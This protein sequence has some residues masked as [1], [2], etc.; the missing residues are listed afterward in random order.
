MTI[1]AFA[2]QQQPAKYR[3]VVI[4]FERRFTAGA[5]RAWR[6]DG[7]SFWNARDANIQEAADY[8]AK[9]KKEDRYHRFECAIA[10]KGAQCEA[11]EEVSDG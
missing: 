2:A 5:F 7:N 6:D 1:S 9:E 3:N 8:D 11:A 10:V 4:G